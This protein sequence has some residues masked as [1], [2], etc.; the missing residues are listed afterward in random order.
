MDVSNSKK[1]YKVQ[2]ILLFAF[3]LT[4]AGVVDTD[5]NL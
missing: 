4:N 1:M 3:Y 2:A 5:F